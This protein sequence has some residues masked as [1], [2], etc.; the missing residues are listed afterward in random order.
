[1]AK[2]HS[3][4]AGNTTLLAPRIVRHDARLTMM[5]RGHSF[6]GGDTTLMAPHIVRYDAGLRLTMGLGIMDLNL[7]NW[8]SSARV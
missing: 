7:L 1:M 5:L 8:F 6:L 3:F 2:G 4:I